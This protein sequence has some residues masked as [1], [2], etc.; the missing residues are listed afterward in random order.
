[1]KLNLKVNLEKIKETILKE[2][3]FFV[4][5]GGVMLLLLLWLTYTT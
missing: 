5:K 3:E 1:M 2:E 4:D